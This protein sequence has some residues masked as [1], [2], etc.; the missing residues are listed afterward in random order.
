MLHEHLLMVPSKREQYFN[1]AQ[2]TIKRWCLSV[3]QWKRGHQH[4][5]V[6]SQG[7]LESPGLK[8]L[9]NANAETSSS[10]RHGVGVWLGKPRHPVETS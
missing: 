10:S 1:C 6:P 3:S 2:A 8:H 9:D 7:V 4:K 5:G